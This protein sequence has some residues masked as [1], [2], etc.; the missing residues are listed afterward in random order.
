LD[1]TTLVSPAPR[2]PRGDHTEQR[3]SNAQGEQYG[4]NSRH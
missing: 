2:D 3:E 1:H 4:V